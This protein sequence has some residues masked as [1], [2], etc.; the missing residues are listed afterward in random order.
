MICVHVVAPNKL[1]ILLQLSPIFDRR[2]H[3]KK[4]ETGKWPISIL[5]EVSVLCVGCLELDVS[6]VMGSHY[7]CKKVTIRYSST[8]Y[9]PDPK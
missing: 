4:I 6:Q 7:R 9:L 2:R 5:T 1:K 8:G 3:K